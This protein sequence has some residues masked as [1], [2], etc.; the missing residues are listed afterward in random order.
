[1]KSRMTCRPELAGV[2]AVTD[3]ELMPGERLYAA[4]EQALRAGVT[5]LQY[6]DKTSVPAERRARAAELQKI[7]ARHRV[8][9]IINDDVELAQETGA[10][11][12][13]L[14]DTDIPLARARAL[15]G[16]AAIIGVSCYNRI[17]PAR[18][19]AAAGADYVAFGS[20]YASVTK[21]G[22]VRAPLSL[23]REAKQAL[24]TPVCAIG[25]ID[26]GNAPALIDCGVD[27]L[28]VISGIFAQNDIESATRQLVACLHRGRSDSPGTN[29]RRS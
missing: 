25:G 26:A 21:P 9:L 2:Y 24:S 29:T 17:E 18:V 28:A 4:V 23:Y 22:A 14:G 5:L 15:L 20:A 6:R 7:C 3:P 11:G 8:P 10:A 1:M 19:A 12:V 13:H 27:L 16:P